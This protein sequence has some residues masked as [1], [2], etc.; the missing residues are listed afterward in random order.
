M[1]VFQ[2]VVPFLCSRHPNYDSNM[3]TKFEQSSRV[4][5]RSMSTVHQSCCQ[6][7]AM[8]LFW[9]AV[10]VIATAITRALGRTGGLPSSTPCPLDSG[11]TE[12][13]RKVS[14]IYR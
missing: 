9:L 11:G 10:S 14:G 12:S 2:V 4:I 5:D 7:V 3:G 1:L 13:N 6:C 8:Q